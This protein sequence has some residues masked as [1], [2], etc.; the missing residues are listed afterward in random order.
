MND[1]HLHNWTDFKETFLP[2]FRFWDEHIR[3]RV[4]GRM[5]GDPFPPLYRFAT[6]EEMVATGTPYIGLPVFPGMWDNGRQF[7]RA[8]R[9]YQAAWMPRPTS[10]S[11]SL[12]LSIRGCGKRP[13][14]LCTA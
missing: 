8:M 2:L 5:G 10:R 13:P 9:R 3:G 12:T 6:N 4:F 14:C 11:F 1:E 7:V